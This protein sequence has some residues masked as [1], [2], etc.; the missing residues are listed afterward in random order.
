MEFSPDAFRT[1]QRMTME[2]YDAA[3]VC[4]NGH[5]INEFA[6]TQPEHNQ[7]FCSKCGSRVISTCTQ[8]N[9]KVRGHHHD[10]PGIILVYAIDLPAFCYQC[11]KPYPW[12]ERRLVAAQD[13]VSEAEKLDER[14]KRILTESLDD[15]IRETPK[16]PTALMHFKKLVAK[17]GSA[18]AEGLKSV[19]V[20][21]L[22]E[23][24]RKQIWP[25]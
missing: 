9:S 12:T 25:S 20:E 13:L 21:V 15:L 7:N 14:E 22:S 17:A 16:T 18:T 19:L 2:G 10:S 4:L 6:E 5:V 11:G 8:C 24:I 23:A 1:G 3:Q